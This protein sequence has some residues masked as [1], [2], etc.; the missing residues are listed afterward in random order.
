M[1]KCFLLALFQLITSASSATVKAAVAAH[2]GTNFQRK[3]LEE[4]S[5]H[6]VP[7]I[8]ELPDIASVLF[9]NVS[10]APS[11]SH[12][13]GVAYNRRN[14]D[15]AAL[16]FTLGVSCVGTM[17]ALICFSVLR[18]QNPVAYQ[19]Q[20]FPEETAEAETIIPASVAS[21][22]DMPVVGLF[23]WVS[24]VLKTTPEEEIAAAGLDGW[25]LLEFH[26]LHRRI[27]TAICPFAFLVCIMHWYTNRDTY[28]SDLL[29][30]LDVSVYASDMLATAYPSMVW[31]VVLISSWHV[32]TAHDRFIERRFEWLKSLP[33]PRATTVLVRNI[34]EEFRSDQSLKDYFGNLFSMD[35]VQSAYIVRKTGSLPY[36]VEEL[37][38]ANYS[39]ALAKRAWEK[40]GCPGPDEASCSYLAGCQQRRLKL[41]KH[42]A[43][44]Q[45]K[46][47]RAVADRDR[48]IC[49][50]SGFVTFNSEL[51]QRLASREQYRRDITEFCLDAPPDPSD[52]IY[53]NLSEDELGS[54]TWAVVGWFCYLAIFLF[55]V[56]VVVVISSWTSL[57]SIEQASPFVRELIEKHPQY[58]SV[59]TGVFSTAALKLFLAFLPW[60]LLAV[61]ERFSNLKA[62]A[63]AQLRLQSWYATFLI[64]FVL[65]VTTLGRGLTATVATILKDPSSVLETLSKNLPET[66]HFY[67]NYV[68]LGWFTLAV[69][70]LRITN[71]LKWLFFRHAC[72]FEADVAKQYCEPEDQTSYGMGA[73]TALVVLMSA[74]T[75]SF[76]TTSPLIL[77]L[78]V[79]YFVLG[80]IVYGYLL[81]FAESKKPDLGGEFWM[82]AVQQVLMILLLYVLIMASILVAKSPDNWLPSASAVSALLVLYWA[83]RRVNNLAFDSLPLEELVKAS[84]AKQ[85]EKQHWSGHYVQPELKPEVLNE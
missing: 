74:I 62:N 48:T 69:E 43:E 6:G 77:P 34:P 46:I 25:C 72:G 65:L 64:I 83:W 84:R 36:L 12:L 39:L 40:Q 11:V 20:R 66:S 78:A 7:D 24:L 9:R 85:A 56:P 26:R 8:S 61:I 76:C 63:L 51:S 59:L 53:K 17:L 33:L 14:G 82:Q 31:L 15:L 55:W 2:L 3:P 49:S 58:L 47:E 1:R 23:D 29:G 27:F 79:V 10:E 57:A 38:Q 35:A 75:F 52:V 80:D 81:I 70:L 37:E 32:V 67:F 18:C 54:T 73:R 16:R 21:V 22:V 5:E 4:N 60:M 44:A 42:V 50:S 41:A 45:D 19:R 30:R 28:D 71:L 13:V 68:V